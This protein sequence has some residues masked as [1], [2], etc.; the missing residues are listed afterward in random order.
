[1]YIVI[2]YCEIFGGGESCERMWGEK[3]GR[4]MFNIGSKE[5]IPSHLFPIN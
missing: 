3:V 4:L 2:H 5:D 1:M